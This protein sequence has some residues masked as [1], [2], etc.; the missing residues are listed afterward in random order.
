MTLE[1]HSIVDAKITKVSDAGLDVVVGENAK[2]V[3]RI[4]DLAWDTHGILESMYDEYHTGDVI[5]IKVMAVNE[6]RFLGSVKDLYPDK[7]PWKNPGYYKVGDKHLGR[8]KR[9]ADF[10][11]FISLES[12]AVA[13]MLKDGVNLGDVDDQE[14]E[15]VI[16]QVDTDLQKIMVALA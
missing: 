8:I 12:G 10:G 5:K 14:I 7:N 9:V 15:V 6:D 1:A 16:T 11:Y 4:I 2:G 3:V 13:L